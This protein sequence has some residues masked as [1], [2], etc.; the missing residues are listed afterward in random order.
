MLSNANLWYLPKKRKIKP[1]SV[2]IKVGHKKRLQ[3]SLCLENQNELLTAARAVV[4]A[5]HGRAFLL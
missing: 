5:T 4:A 2:K 1:R 3:L